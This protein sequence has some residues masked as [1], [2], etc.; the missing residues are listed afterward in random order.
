MTNTDLEFLY[1]WF[2]QIEGQVQFGDSK[3]SLLI[4]GNAVLLAVSGGL[5]RMVSGCQGD[6][7][8]VSCLQPSL[9]L[10]L[11]TIAAMLLTIGLV[12][13]L[14]AAR[15]AKIHDQPPP[16][17]FL[18]S[19]IALIDRD[20]FAKKYVDASPGDLV[21]E[22]LTSIHGKAGLATRKFRLLKRAIDATLRCARSRRA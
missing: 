20:V 5:I 6:A 11:A 17:L 21:Q 2:D 9:S 18:L 10:G 13:A 16:A 7:V 19:Y 8:G 15:P 14:L 12:Y 22:A 3:A 4:A 1:M